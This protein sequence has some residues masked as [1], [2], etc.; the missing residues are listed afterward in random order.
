MIFNDKYSGD[1]NEIFNKTKFKEFNLPDD[2]NYTTRSLELIHQ[3]YCRWLN[4]R[5]GIYLYNVKLTIADN[6]DICSESILDYLF[7]RVQ[8]DV[9]HRNTGSDKS[10][11]LILKTYREGSSTIHEGYFLMPMTETEKNNS[12]RGDKTEI[13]KDV[14]RIFSR[15]L[16]Q[17]WY[18]VNDEIFDDEAL[19]LKFSYATLGEGYGVIFNDSSFEVHERG[20][21]MLCVIPDL[22]TDKPGADT[23]SFRTRD[24]Y[25]PAHN[26]FCT[27][28]FE[29]FFIAI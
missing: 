28:L 24:G 20:F 18:H 25:N 17:Y 3:M 27:S 19:G 15:I 8:G 22:F 29:P 5:Y 16:T 10:I 6:V 1:E 11:G 21:N 14:H 4:T 2:A 9:E 7:H 26:Y 13:S 12:P 23:A